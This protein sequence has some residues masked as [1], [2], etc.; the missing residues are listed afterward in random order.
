MRRTTR[1]SVIQSCPYDLHDMKCAAITAM[2][3]VVKRNIIVVICYLENVRRENVA[4]AFFS[5]FHSK[6]DNRSKCSLF[7]SVLQMSEKRNK[8]S[9]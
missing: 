5:G 2:I 6:C 8:K 4:T 7:Q 3:I 9:I 1:A